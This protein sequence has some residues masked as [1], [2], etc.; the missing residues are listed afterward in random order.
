MDCQWPGKWT[1][2]SLFCAVRQ[3]VTFSSYLYSTK[4]PSLGVKLCLPDIYNKEL[5][6]PC[7]QRNWPSDV[8]CSWATRRSQLNCDLVTVS[9]VDGPLI[10]NGHTS[11]LVHLKNCNFSLLLPFPGKCG[12]TCRQCMRTTHVRTHI[13]LCFADVVCLHGILSTLQSPDGGG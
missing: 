6:H 2:H 5:H 12:A 8:A 1:G 4:H 11:V 7:K 13:Q 9:L 3:L 10:N